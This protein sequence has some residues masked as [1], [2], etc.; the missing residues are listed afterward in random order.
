MNFNMFNLAM[1]NRIIIKLNSITSITLNN[2]GG[3]N[4]KPKL[5]EKPANP[6]CFYSYIDYTT[7]LDF[8]RLKRD[9]HLFLTQLIQGPRTQPKRKHGIS[10]INVDA[11]IGIN[12]PD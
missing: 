11:T 9:Y 6:N 12:V 7:I 5:V 3:L 4:R 2:N 8:R 1:V 10:L